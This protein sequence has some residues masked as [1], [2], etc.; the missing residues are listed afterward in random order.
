MW[1]Y[2]LVHAFLECYA[3]MMA[4]NWGYDLFVVVRHDKHPGLGY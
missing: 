3:P 1:A 4:E 2:E